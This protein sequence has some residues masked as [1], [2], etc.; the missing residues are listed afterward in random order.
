METISSP[1]DAE[2]RPSGL[3]RT[4]QYGNNF[5]K[6]RIPHIDLRLNR[7][8]QYGNLYIAF[9]FAIILTCLNRTMQYGNS[10]GLKRQM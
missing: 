1:Y 7:T 5:Q 6:E 8:M 9:F 4:M 10:M 2:A 3:N